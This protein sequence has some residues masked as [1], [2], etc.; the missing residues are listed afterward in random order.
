MGGYKGLKCCC[1][2]HTGRISI[3]QPDPWSASRLFNSNR[4][5]RIYR[6]IRLE[7]QSL[8]L[9]PIRYQLNRKYDFALK[10]HKSEFFFNSARVQ[11]RKR[12]EECNGK[13]IRANLLFNIGQYSILN[14]NTT[15]QNHFNQKEVCMCISILVMIEQELS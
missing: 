6:L 2:C 12:N 5:D 7:I 4:V 8:N 13:Y 14:N 10:L 9:F 1:C 15:S 3:E 11:N